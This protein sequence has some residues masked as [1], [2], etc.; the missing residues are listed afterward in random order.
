[1]IKFKCVE[2]DEHVAE[3]GVTIHRLR[4]F[5]QYLRKYKVIDQRKAYKY[6][7]D[8]ERTKSDRDMHDMFHQLQEEV[9]ISRS[10][11]P[12]NKFFLAH[13]DHYWKT[14][15]NQVRECKGN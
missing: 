3:A 6:Q 1:M 14:L 9:L 12:D 15:E 4:A 11:N 7:C 10:T 2:S 13:T 8:I 5:V